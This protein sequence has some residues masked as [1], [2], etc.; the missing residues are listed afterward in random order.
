MVS[1]QNLAQC[2]QRL[3]RRQAQLILFGVRQGL[4][5]ESNGGGHVGHEN[6]G[7]RQDIWQ[8]KLRIHD[9]WIFLVADVKVC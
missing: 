5:G 2:P 8:F 1:D 9:V 7:K 3:N 4:A 6:H